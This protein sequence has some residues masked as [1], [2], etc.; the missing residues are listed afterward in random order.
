MKVIKIIFNDVFVIKSERH[1]DERGFFSESFVSK[2]FIELVKRIFFDNF[3]IQ[4]N[5]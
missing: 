2:N 3:L 4:K 1:N 5:V